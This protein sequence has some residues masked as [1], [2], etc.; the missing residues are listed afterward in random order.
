MKALAVLWLMSG[1][2][3]PGCYYGHLAVGQARLLLASRSVESILADP[4]TPAEL[5][6]RLE[7]VQEVVAFAADLGL[8]VDGQYR[9]YVEW[10]GDQVVTTLVATL[11]GQITPSDFW[12]P[13]IG[14]APYK[15]F[16]DPERAAREAEA[17]AN[18]GYDTC[19]VPV[20]A[21]S[22]LG[23]FE[24]PLT[25]PMVR[26]SLPRLAETVLHEL[27]HA[28]VFVASQPDFNEG[29]ATFIGQEAAVR[30]AARQEPDDD[31][32]ARVRTRVRE[33]REV[34]AVLE[35]FRTR[36]TELYEDA[37]AGS[38]LSETRATLEAATR[39]ELGALPLTTRD[40]A[41]L[42]EAVWLNDACQALS[43]TYQADLARWSAVLEATGGD[44]PALVERVRE[45]ADDHDPRAAILDPEPASP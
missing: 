12:F 35:R 38:D 21:Y 36:I 9:S 27:V 8:S 39:A 18:D 1:T 6:T 45:A 15:G 16:F 7:H 11:P 44:L 25:G 32:E 33:D 19:L 34:A 2:L 31:G 40:P 43:G 22:T 13:L 23:W 10:P 3:L 42:A 5:A 30:F 4:E 29:L 14:H 26:Q 20:I 24:D 41:R 37:P 17:L 28:T